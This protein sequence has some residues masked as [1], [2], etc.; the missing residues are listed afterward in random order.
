MDQLLGARASDPESTAA[1]I[2][3]ARRLFDEPAIAS[4]RL[5]RR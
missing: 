2:A 5:D 1:A 4:V 3:V